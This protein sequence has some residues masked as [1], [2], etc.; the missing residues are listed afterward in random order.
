M[1]DLSVKQELIEVA[2]GQRP[3]HVLIK[4]G[5]VINVYSGELLPANVA[6]YKDRIAYVGSRE[7]FIG[8][9]TEVIDA[10]GYYVSPGYIE[11]HA[12]PWVLYNPVSL[13]S[14]VLPLGTTT[15]VND[16]LFFYL[17]MGTDG[18]KK[19][20]YDLEELPGNLLWLVRIVSQAD[21]PGER[22]WFAT[23]RVKE[24]LQLDQV[25]GTAEVTRWPLLY[26]GD[27][28][29][30]EPVRVAK[31]HGKISDGHTAG[32]SY[33]KLNA[34]VAS[35]I[36]ACHEA[37]TAQE[38]LDRLRLGMWATLRNSSLRPDLPEIIKVIT[39][40]KVDT[41]RILL[42]TDGPHP[43]FI[44][45]EGCVD[46]LLRKAVA[47]GLP[48]I[49]ALQ[50]VT[51]NPATFFHLDHELGGIAPG[52]RADVLLLPDL[53]QFRPHVV[54]SGG[55]VVA[56]DGVLEAPLPKINWD[57]YLVRKPFEL[58]KEILLDPSLY[59]F[60]HTG[61][62][63]PVIHFKIAV[64]TSKKEMDLPSENGYA[65]LSHHSQL[66]Y[67]ALIDRKGQWVSRGILENFATNLEGLAT[68][69]N[70]TTELLVI[71][72]NPEAMAQAAGRVYD[73]G[74]GI[75]VVEGGKPILEIPLPLT[76]MMTTSADFAT[77]VDYQ[78]QFLKVMK[79]RGYPFHDILYTLLFL[80]C[81]FLPGLRL[82]PH[83]L[84]DVKTDQIVRP[85]EQLGE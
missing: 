6:L 50:M 82:V 5:R 72:R 21:F 36:D 84:Y 73:M 10:E 61:G 45:E 62:K 37:I 12:H 2:R 43:A 14:K 32:C 51:I 26:Q 1:N 33:D 23:E 30:L 52:R 67:A 47:L 3:A 65:D 42:T 54:I 58:S 85:A 56:K 57:K 41:R 75:C 46:G 27:P 81:D 17:H 4:N 59:R 83:G 38:V 79:E 44:E 40:E 24:L 13:I 53:V 7:D 70:T 64:I 76:G 9:E 35:G 29:A 19:M 77:A 15:I 68:T 20:V 34:I 66:V 49:E 28:F 18:F 69:Y 22:E 78:N 31:E 8:E 16:N 55:K 80:T 25:V 63:A 48:P 39:E 71:G 60:P 11:P 74:G